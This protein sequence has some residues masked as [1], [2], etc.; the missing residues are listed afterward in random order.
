MRRMREK[1]VSSHSFLLIG[2]VF[3]DV[4]IAHTLID[5]F[6]FLFHISWYFPLI[7]SSFLSWFSFSLFVAFISFSVWLNPL[8]CSISST[9]IP[10]SSVN[11][12]REDPDENDPSDHS[13]LC[14]FFSSFKELLL[15]YLFFL[16]SVW[17]EANITQYSLIIL[18]ICRWCLISYLIGYWILVVSCITHCHH[19]Q[20]KEK[21]STWT[22]LLF[23]HL[24]VCVCLSLSLSLLS[25]TCVSHTLWLL[26][27]RWRREKRV[28][29]SPSPLFSFL[30][31][32]V[33]QSFVVVL[34]KYLRLWTLLHDKL[35]HAMRCIVL[36]C[37]YYIGPLLLSQHFLS[38]SVTL[39]H[40][41]HFIHRMVWS[42][43]LLFFFT[44][45]I[46]WLTP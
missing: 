40:P 8:W 31:N 37:L 36:V 13:I 39:V 16:H 33:T 7:P 42:F 4:L 22:R 3:F 9:F 34:V 23:V 29:P 11:P 27:R 6:F 10:A 24:F 28:W 19:H 18:M 43:F 1:R 26:L 2:W 44:S 38:L 30:G 5:R 45:L 14:F 25:D 17:P 12:L 20:E 21:G 32:Q 41:C 15:C 35:T 46:S